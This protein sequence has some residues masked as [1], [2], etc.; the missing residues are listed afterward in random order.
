MP[1]RAIIYIAAVVCAGAGSLLHAALAWRMPDP[2]LFFSL[3]ILAVCLSTMKITLPR[4]T[5]TMS[6]GFVAVL[7]GVALLSCGETIVIACTSGVVQSL[8]G[9]RKRPMLVQVAFNGA[10]LSLSALAAYQLV[11]WAGGVAGQGCP[12]ALLGVAAAADYIVNT[13]LVSTVLCLIERTPLLRIVSNCNLWAVPYFLVGAIVAGGVVTPRFEANWLPAVAA[14]P[15]LW[16]IF[17]CYRQ[18]VGL[19]ARER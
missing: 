7:A 10:A 13:F 4:M 9:A 17:D 8:W 11:Q 5:G 18:Y 19:L 16:M 1:Q 6:A 2:R 3:L 14:L 15:V 12:A